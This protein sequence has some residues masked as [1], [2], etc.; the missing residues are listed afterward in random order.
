MLA[1]AVRICEAKFGVLHRYESGF[2]YPTATQDIPPALAEFQRQRGAIAPLPGTSLDRLMR[3]KAV[4]HFADELAEHVP[5][6]A[7]RLG[8]AR[9]IVIVP[10]VK[11]DRLV[12][13]IVIYRQEVRPFTDKQIE[14]V[15]NFASQAVIAIENTRLLNELRESLEQQTASNDL[16]EVISRSAFDLRPVFETIAESAVRLGDAR[17]AFIYRFDGE[18]LRMVADYATPTEFKKW[19][20]DHPIKPGR[21]SASGRA[22]LERRTIHIHDVRADPEYSF[23]AKE[24]EAFRTVLT[25]PMLKGNDLLGVILTYRLEVRPFTDKQIALLE[26]FAD[27]AV[28]AIENVRLFD[29]VQART[30]EL[31]ESLEQ[32]TA[33]SEVLGVISSSPG[34]LAPVFQAMLANAVRICGAKFGVLWLKEGD[35]YRSVAV[36]DLPPALAELRQREP[37]TRMSPSTGTVR[38]LT[39]R[40]VVHVHDMRDDPAYIERNPRAVALVELGGARTAMFTPLLKESEGIGCFV[41]YRQEVRS[42]TDKQIALVTNFAAQA[43]IAIENTRLLNELRQR[44]SDLS[45]SLE[46]QTA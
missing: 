2:F 17:L 3:T 4:V 26:T 13:T 22:A 9:T 8:G 20:A 23:G 21:D 43:V 28:I 33:T 12:G 15:K 46:Q 42:F 25:V 14:L 19:M 27:Q 39:A 32:Q 30:R 16:L 10:M 11:D 5:G 7:A 41:I 29:E 37:F 6:A 45:E 38:A 24:V 18:I 31:S 34:E 44:T 40:R 35:G 36:H 1:N